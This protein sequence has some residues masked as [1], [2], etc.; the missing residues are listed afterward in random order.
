[1]CS[2]PRDGSLFVFRGEIAV[3]VV[4]EPGA[5]QA[6][7]EA[8]VQ[9]IRDAGLNTHLSVGT[10]RTLIG[11][12]G[13]SHTKELLRDTLEATPGVEKVV[14]ILQP[15]KLVSREFRPSGTVVRVGGAGF[16]GTAGAAGG[17][18]AGRHGGDGR[19]PTAAGC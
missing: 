8:V 5:T 12:V 15:F 11:V 4:M 3:I 2:R 19:A 10:E 7:L 14:R 16:G 9:K 18:A 6:Q 1:M 17:G 13:D